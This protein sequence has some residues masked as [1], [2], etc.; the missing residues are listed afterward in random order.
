MDADLHDMQSFARFSQPVVYLL[1]PL[2]KQRELIAMPCKHGR[3]FERARQARRQQ[4]EELG[5]DE[6]G[7][8]QFGDDE[9]DMPVGYC[10]CI[11]FNRRNQLWDIADVCVKRGLSPN[12]M[13]EIAALITILTTD[14]FTFNHFNRVMFDLFCGEYK[15]FLKAFRRQS[16]KGVSFADAMPGLVARWQWRM[17]PNA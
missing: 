8:D 3:T 6:P 10:D 12:Q 9:H 15:E 13:K 2:L 14:S 17:M 1:E 4:F 7:D 5:Q 11:P 16:D